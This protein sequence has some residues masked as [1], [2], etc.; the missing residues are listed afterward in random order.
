MLKAALGNYYK[1]PQTKGAVSAPSVRTTLHSGGG[2]FW[3]SHLGT[4]SCGFFPRGSLPNGPTTLLPHW[5]RGLLYLPYVS[6]W[7]AQGWKFTLQ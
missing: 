7:E 4:F 5:R 1:V 2:S 6:K 3:N